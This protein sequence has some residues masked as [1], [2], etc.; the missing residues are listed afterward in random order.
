MTDSNSLPEANDT[1][2]QE[3]LTHLKNL[4][5]TTDNE[6]ARMSSKSPEESQKF[7]DD[8]VDVKKRLQEDFRCLS[9]S[10]TS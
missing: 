6:L 9:G 8:L 4:G 2:R 10:I 3:L 1:E 7:I 5:F